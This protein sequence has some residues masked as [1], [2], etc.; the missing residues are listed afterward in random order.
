MDPELA[1]EVGRDRKARDAEALDAALVGLDQDGAGAAGH[2][3][4]FERQRRHG[5][6]LRDHHHRHPPDDA[7][8][9]RPDREQA[10]PGGGLLE[11]RHVAQQSGK[12]EHELLRLLA[13]HCKPG[14]RQL[15]VEVGAHIGR[16]GFAEHHARV[17]D[18]VGQDA[19][20]AR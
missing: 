16:A 3:Q 7:V 17:L 11:H 18:G 6:A 2:P 1:V 19:V 13:E 10:P 12:L 20:I 14:D 9:L 4:H 5:D 15:F 8:A